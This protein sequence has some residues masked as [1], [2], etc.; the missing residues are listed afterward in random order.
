MYCIT[1]GVSTNVL[2]VSSVFH[3]TLFLDYKSKQIFYVICT[4]IL[5][6]K[7]YKPFFWHDQYVSLESYWWYYAEIQVH[8]IFALFASCPNSWFSPKIFRLKSCSINKHFCLLYEV[9]LYYAQKRKGMIGK[10]Y[11][12]TCF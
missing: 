2:F 12:S 9:Y 11:M 8:K 7:Y 4:V 10:S 3:I 5:Y 6:I 1:I